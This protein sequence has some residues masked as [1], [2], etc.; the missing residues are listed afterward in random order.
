MHVRTKGLDYNL[1]SSEVDA[2]KYIQGSKFA[3]RLP[4]V[5]SIV[6]ISLATLLCVPDMKNCVKPRPQRF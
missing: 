1:F 3:S 5:A 4:P 6:E 2:T